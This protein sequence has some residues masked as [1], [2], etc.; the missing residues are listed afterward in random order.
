[1]QPLK[2]NKNQNK[3][4]QKRKSEITSAKENALKAGPFGSALKKK[5][6]SQVAIKYMVKNR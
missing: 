4:P 5:F 3:I 1:M 6:M 2:I